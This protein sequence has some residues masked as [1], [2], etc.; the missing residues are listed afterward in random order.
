MAKEVGR[1]EDLPRDGGHAEAEVLRAQHVPL[2]LWSGAAR[3]TSARL[4]RL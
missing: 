1:D 3:G 2:P 4:H